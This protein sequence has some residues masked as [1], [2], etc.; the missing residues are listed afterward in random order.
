MKKIIISLMV[1]VLTLTI[2]F[3]AASA[4]KLAGGWEIPAAEGTALPEDAQAAFD[5][6]MEKLIGA[7]YTP[8][9]LL[10]T[11]VVAGT[12]YCFLCQIAPVVPD[13]VPHWALVYLYANLDGDVE[14]MNVY[15]LDIG[16]YAFPEE[17]E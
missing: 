7:E 16:A 17:A 8:V 10:A 6:A 12:N 5:K 13:P 11:Q 15:D 3:A 2:C 1:L 4:E 9:A 14:I